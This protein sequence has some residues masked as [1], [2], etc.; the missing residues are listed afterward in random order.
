MWKFNFLNHHR[1]HLLLELSC[2]LDSAKFG[3]AK[4]LVLE[5]YRFCYWLYMCTMYLVA[6]LKFCE[7]DFCSTEPEGL[8]KFSVIPRMLFWC[9]LPQHFSVQTFFNQLTFYKQIKN[10]PNTIKFN[11]Q[12]L[13][14]CKVNDTFGILF[15]TAINL[16][17]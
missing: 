14:Y 4:Q 9:L 15:Y 6:K 1:T 8:R 5:K 13:L 7:T 16:L 17:I 3:I 2:W 12:K 10:K 11:I